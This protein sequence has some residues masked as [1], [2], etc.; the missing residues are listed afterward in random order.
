MIEKTKIILLKVRFILFIIKQGFL[1]L[2]R[3][4]YLCQVAIQVSS[5]FFY[6]NTLVKGIW[7]QIEKRRS[8][9]IFRFYKNRLKCVCIELSNIRKCINARLL[10]WN[11]QENL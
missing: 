8:K 7:N 9:I 2:F 5:N 4:K 6:V 3:K 1:F 10:K 11:L